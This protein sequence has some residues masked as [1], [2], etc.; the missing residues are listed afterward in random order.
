MTIFQVEYLVIM[1]GNSTFCDS[2]ESFNRL[3]KVDSRLNVN[4]NK[5]IFKPENVTVDYDIISGSID[6]IN[7]R[8]F[9]IVFKYEANE[10]T[11]LI[12]LLKVIKGI[13][14]SQ[15]WRPEVLR[16]DVSSYYAKKSY[17]LL[18][19][20]ENLMRALIASF[21]LKTI[22]KSWVEDTSPKDVKDAITKSKRK[23]DGYM[24]ALY[25]VDFIHLSDF[26]FKPY[27]TNELSEMYSQID[28]IKDSSELSLS[29][30]KECIPKSNWQRYFAEVVECDDLFLKKRW[31]LLYELRCIVA[32][33]SIIDKD[34][35]ENV[36]R[37]S[38]EIKVQ[39][40]KAFSK[41]NE[42]DVPAENAEE[43]AESA[44]LQ[45]NAQA[46][47]FLQDW[48][49]LQDQIIKI[50]SEL[51]YMDS[52]FHNGDIKTKGTVKVGVMDVNK[53]ANYLLFKS[54][55]DDEFVRDVNFL[56]NT[57]NRFVHGVRTETSSEHL[58]HLINDIK[59]IRT[60]LAEVD[61]EYSRATVLV[62]LDDNVPEDMSG[63][64]RVGSV[65]AY[66]NNN[67]A[68]DCPDLIDNRE[69]NSISE[70]T[71]SIARR[72][73]LYPNAVSVEN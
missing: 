55:V 9:H 43:V 33:N 59:E 7:Q 65:E 42:V 20:I 39:L 58:E 26:L 32:H 29:K 66:D 48:H 28:K 16:D 6:E 60:S 30:L 40:E 18:H 73:K 25:Q 11:N 50:G 14:H 68:I 17:P 12:K 56:T 47:I 53:I 27:A 8:Y 57:R 49:V 37:L 10:P 2:V 46:A 72:L 51:G 15:K 22:G 24:N 35:Y 54:M 61:A 67:R 13:V 19:D 70:L 38:E 23:S 34:G 1:D 69:Y 41:L 36:K 64:Y 3:L 45:F 62:S 44:A 63:I 31:E 21:M 5:I 71:E 52:N 4:N